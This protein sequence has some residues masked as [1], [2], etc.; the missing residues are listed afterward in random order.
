MYPGTHA[1]TFP[2]K[3]ALI[4]AGSGEVVTYRELDER[5]NRLAQLLWSRGLRPG[6]H[7]AIFMENHPRYFEVAWAAL[8]SGLYLT[9]VNSYLTAPEVAHIVEDCDAQA[10]VTSASLAKVAAEAVSDAPARLH[11]RLV[12]DDD[13]HGFERFEDAIAAYPAVPLAEE[14]L[15]D[16]MLY[17]SGTTGKPKGIKRP[18]SNGRAADGVGMAAMLGSMFNITSDSIYLSPAPLYHSAPITFSTAV[19]SIGGTVVCME[20]FDASAALDA[21]ER[22]RC[23]RAQFVPTMF[24]RM[25]KLPEAERLAHDV[26]SMAVAIHAAAPCPVEVK[27]QMMDWWGPVI[28]EYY[29]ATEMSGITLVTPEEWLARPGTVGKSALGAIHI[30]D[31]DGNELPPGEAGTIWFER[32]GTFEYHNDPDKTDASRN[33]LGFTAVGDVGYVDEDGYLYLTDRKAYM[34]ISGGVNI[35]PQEAENVLT[36]HP[37]V[38]DVAVF[39]VP[40][41]EFGEEVKAVVQPIDWSTAGP[42]LEEE[43]LAY[44][45]EQLAHYKCP[46]TIDFD[47]ELPRLPTG[48]LYKREIKDRYWS[49]HATRIV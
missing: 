17:S 18:P 35:Y 29:G 19:Q 33:H 32:G 42:A 30:L 12:V 28:H 14:P 7:I 38:Y 25:L 43:L 22:Y 15:G 26:S 44:C 37:K 39:G 1:R 49:G 5:S 10:F 4:M 21:I 2:D 20:H 11:I 23:N 40:N 13:A 31:D 24:V 45:R 3:A 16:F 27:R 41:V 9:T 6:D 48:K 8:R 34:V 36:M 47:R 46:R